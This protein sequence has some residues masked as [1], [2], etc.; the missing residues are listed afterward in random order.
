MLSR[1]AADAPDFQA[2]TLDGQTSQG[3]IVA[4]DSQQL[5]LESASG[6]ATLPLA[7]VAVVSRPSAAP[8]DR[9]APAVW[10]ELADQS[11]LAATEYTVRGSTAQIKL[12]GGMAIELP[13]RSILWVRFGQP[14][15]ED[16]KLTKQWTDIVETKANGDMLVVRKNGALDYLEG[17]QG[18]LDAEVCKFELDKEIIPVKR[19][20]VEGIVY[21]HAAA[22]ELPDAAGQLSATDGCRFA[23]RAVELAADG[24]GVKI[25]TPAGLAVTLP[26]DAVARFDFSAGKI[27]YLSD[28]QPESAEY[29]PLLGFKQDLPGV[30]DFYQFRRDVGFEQ[31]PLRLDGKTFRKGLSLQSR[32]ALV[33]KLP[34][35]FHAFKAVVGIDDSVRESGNVRLEVHADGKIL[36][37][38]D[39]A[40]SEPAREL[41]LEIG[42]V[43][44][45]E[46]VADY[47][48][49]LDIGDRL[50]L[51]EA[52]VIK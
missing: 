3:R 49:E 35:K 22:A 9:R 37:Q 32:T 10:V 44:R 27:A 23:L 45:L 2:Q 17:V 48:R 39:I 11:G 47:G 1:A 12:A 8:R 15:G 42:G 18:D 50:D 6:R 41:E 13:T 31:N 30:R 20:K 36:W 40:G 46:I 38:G 34:G 19:A 33:Y 21:L 24:A 43:K 25:T 5:V 16:Q 4:L 26:L 29:L 14:A 7:T 51:C 52:R 28:L